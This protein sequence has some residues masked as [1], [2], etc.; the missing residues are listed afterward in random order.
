MRLICRVFF[1]GSNFQLLP[2]SSLRQ[3]PLSPS[4]T[5]PLKVA[6]PSPAYKILSSLGATAIAPIEPPKYLSEIFFQ[7]LP[8]SVVFQTPPPVAPKKKVFLFL[9][10]PA[11]L[12]LRPPLKG[13]ICLYFTLLKMAES[14]EAAL[15]FS[16]C[17]CTVH[18]VNTAAIHKIVFIISWFK[19]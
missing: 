19:K 10:L 15:L 2:A 11:T 6:S 14:K 3:I 4:L 17:A 16:F 7:L 13:P 8:P 1:K 12:P 9:K 5:F 18:A